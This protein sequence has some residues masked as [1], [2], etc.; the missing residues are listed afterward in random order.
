MITI[1]FQDSFGV[2]VAKELVDKFRVSSL[3]YVREDVPVYD[4]ATGAVTSA[5][6]T[7]N[8]AGAV[9]M[10]H[11]IEE[12]GVSGR[13][14]LYVWMCLADIGDQLPTTRD[15]LVYLG[16]TWKVTVIDPILTGDKLYACRVTGAFS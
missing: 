16:K 13:Q 6:T 8:S 9:E 12:G 11:N 3:D 15:H 1:A 5:S 10:V 2:P 7:F 14:E 4:P